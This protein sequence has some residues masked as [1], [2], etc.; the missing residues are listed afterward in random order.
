LFLG[1]GAV[2][3]SS[4]DEQDIRKLGGFASKLPLTYSMMLIGSL[5]LMGFPFLSGF[6]SK[7]S[8]LEIA[9]S[10]NTN[11][12]HFSYFL[13]TLSVF[14]TS[15]YSTRLLFLV[16][17]SEPNGTREITFTAKES[18][19]KI[20]IP[21]CILCFFSLFIGFLSQE[22]FIGFGSSFWKNSIFVLPS[23][24]FLLDIEFIPLF[25]KIIPLILSF[26][27]AIVSFFLYSLKLDLF[28]TLKQTSEFRFIYNFINRRWYFDKF[29]NYYIS[30]SV[31]SSGYSFF[32]LTIDRG[33]LEQF[34]PFGITQFI[35]L[36]FYFLKNAYNGTLFHY[37]FFL[38]ISFFIFYFLIIYLPFFYS[39]TE[40][41]LF[42]IFFVVFIF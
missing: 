9:F 36:F 23:K 3:H 37:L 28:F 25:F 38:L 1:A 39:L 32:Y 7:D 17:L 34:G 24:Y 20:L 29:Y 27:G 33:L 4:N 26:L 13:G 21:L 5:A 35:R 8:I 18:G 22:L 16:F 41:L 11:L 40:I 10:N 19:L 14:S 42:F 15:F 6:Y 30:Q 2:I 12:G 31:L